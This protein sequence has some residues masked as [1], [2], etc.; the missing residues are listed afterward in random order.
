CWDIA[1]Q[2]DGKIVLCGD[3]QSR[4]ESLVMRLNSD[5]SLDTTFNG[6]GIFTMHYGNNSE[7]LQKVIIKPD[8]KIV[9][10][11]H[12]QFNSN[13]GFLIIQLLPDGTL[14]SSFGVNG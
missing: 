10:G 8:G 9:A 12:T 1:L 2:D 6:T 5:G 4:S 7:S 3:I 11:G 14:D 13:V